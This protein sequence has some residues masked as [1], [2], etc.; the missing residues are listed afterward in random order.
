MWCF[1][2][3]LLFLLFHINP[4]HVT[5]DEIMLKIQSIFLSLLWRPVP[6]LGMVVGVIMIFKSLKNN[7]VLFLVFDFLVRMEIG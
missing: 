6:S 1:G 4:Y 3:M 7:I 5:D 2:H